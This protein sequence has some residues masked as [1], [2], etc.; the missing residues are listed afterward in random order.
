MVDIQNGKKTFRFIDLFA[1]IGG[2]RL[3]FEAHGGECVF[4]GINFP[5]KLIWKIFLIHLLA[6]SLRLM[7]KVSPITMSCWPGFPARI[8]Q[9]KEKCIGH[10]KWL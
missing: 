9:E 7:K 6:I 2:I 10:A 4:S 3:G 8:L 1:G 5:E